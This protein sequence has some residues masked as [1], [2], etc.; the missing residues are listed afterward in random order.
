M[1]GIHKDVA[2]LAQ[3]PTDERVRALKRIIPCSIVKKILR[4]ATRNAYCSRLPKW[5]MVWFVIGLG[6]FCTDSYRQIFR[7]LNRFRP[8]G[9][10][11]RSTLCEARQRLGVA[12]LRWL[13]EA[14]VKLW[15]T[16]KTPSCFYDGMRLMALDGF[17]VDVPDTPDNDRVFGRPRNGHAS[18]AFP[19]ARILAL[20]EVGTHI[21]WKYLIKPMRRAEITWPASCCAS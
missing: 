16:L 18:G 4:R 6:L 3:Q 15:G 17:L 1:L 21:L 12:P 13:F 8:G 20:C 2:E 14:V 9:T 19:Q 10:P 7:W 11:E 5:F